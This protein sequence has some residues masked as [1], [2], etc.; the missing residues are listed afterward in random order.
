ML[1]ARH[2]AAK[3]LDVERS[4]EAEVN[5]LAH[6]VRGQEVKRDARKIAVERQTQ[7]TDIFGRRPMPFLQRNHYISIGRSGHTAVVVAEIYARN[8]QANIVDDALQV[9]WGNFMANGVLDLII[10]PALS[11]MRVPVLAR[12]CSRNAP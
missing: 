1:V 7:L 12:A 6:D 3:H 5:R 4:R 8:R 11:S 9:P 10:N 2:V